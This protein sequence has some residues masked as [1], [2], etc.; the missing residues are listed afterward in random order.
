MLALQCPYNRQLHA[1]KYTRCCTLC[2]AKGSLAMPR[3]YRMPVKLLALV[4]QERL[5][6]CMLI[7]RAHFVA[8]LYSTKTQ[9][10][11]FGA[12]FLHFAQFGFGC[13]CYENRY[14]ELLLEGSTPGNFVASC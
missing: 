14:Q 5:N 4:V 13:V 2:A 3:N 12:A 7:M 1:L 9:I 8:L 10:A 11:L 6:A